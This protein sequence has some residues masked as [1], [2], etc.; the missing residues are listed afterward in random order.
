MRL[1]TC[2]VSRRNSKN[3][4]A[5]HVCTKA[6]LARLRSD[7]GHGAGDRTWNDRTARN[8]HLTPLDQLHRAGRIAPRASRNMV[9]RRTA[10][11]IQN[12]ASSVSDSRDHPIDE[13]FARLPLRLRPRGPSTRIEIAAVPVIA[14][15][16]A[17][18]H[19]AGIGAGTLGHCSIITLT[20]AP[21]ALQ[22]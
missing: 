6:A 13:R 3:K 21:A 7:S 12:P 10:S 1:D 5:Y 19:H 11:H 18:A 17:A 4:A 14:T 20:P 2:C 22:D 8:D 15:L 16:I 9:A